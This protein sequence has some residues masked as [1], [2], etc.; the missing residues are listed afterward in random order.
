[1]Q[2]EGVGQW[3]GIL[4]AR[5]IVLMTAVLSTDLLM[6]VLVLMNDLQIAQLGQGSGLC[7]ICSAVY[8]AAERTLLLS[9]VV[10]FT[11]RNDVLTH[12]P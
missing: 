5:D 11:A 12:F 10:P 9:S 7:G 2:F 8:D 6:Y 4:K 3:L 1:M